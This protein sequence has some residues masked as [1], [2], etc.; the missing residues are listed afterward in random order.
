MNA[1]VATTNA[2][3]RRMANFTGEKII[4]VSKQCRH[5]NRKKLLMK[6]MVE[7]YL[8]RRKRDVCVRLQKNARKCIDKNTT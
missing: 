1:D 4:M 6:M 3:I 7:K 5:S 8:S 2:V